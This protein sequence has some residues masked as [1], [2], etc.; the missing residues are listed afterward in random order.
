MHYKH[1]LNN[2][3]KIF[4]DFTDKHKF[5]K[6]FYF[7]DPNEVNSKSVKYPAVFGVINPLT[8]TETAI[9]MNFSI[10]FADIVTTNGKPQI[11]VLSD[12]I[13]NAC[14]LIVHLRK[15]HSISSMNITAKPFVEMMDDRLTGVT[16]DFTIQQVFNYDLSAIPFN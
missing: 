4:K 3:V 5:I 10:V 8:I 14:D 15:T 6:S 13:T 2:L 9:N 1:T 11:E 16:V 7:E 12:Q